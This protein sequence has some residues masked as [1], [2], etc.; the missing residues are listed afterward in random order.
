M[1]GEVPIPDHIP[2]EQAKMLV[3]PDNWSFYTQPSGMV[4]KKNQ[5]G[6][7][8]DYDPNPK[9]EN[10][11]N[12]LKS[13]YPNLIR[14]KTKSWIDVYVMN[15]LGH[16]QDG[17]PVYP[18]FASEVHIAEEEIPVAA[19]HP[20]YVGV[21]FGLT[22]AA[23][24]GQKVRGRWFLQSEIVAIDMGI[25]RFAE[26]LRNELSTRF[27]AAS[28][29][30]IY[31]DPAGDFRAQTDESTPF[32]ILRGA[33]LK[34]FP[35]PSNS[36][37]LRLE[38]VSSQLTKMVEGKPYKRMEVSGERYADKPDKNMFSHVHDAAQYLFL[39][40]GEGRALMNSQKPARPVIAKRNFDVFNRGP[41]QRN[42]PSF[43]SRM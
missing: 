18:M 11:K 35:A 19:G 10:T 13:Y 34:A 36:V 30:I 25:V 16:I 26:V 39:G 41:K 5:D 6:E 31:G 1:S 12:M 33:G 32:H 43:W 23:V 9:A 7:I 29:V 22:P 28:E 14:G 3:K 2:R 20:V 24:F 27:A 21:D 42:K 38:S 17:K 4:E 8:E 37:D 15:Q 40:A